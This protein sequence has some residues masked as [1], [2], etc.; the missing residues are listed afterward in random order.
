MRNKAISRDPL[1]Q[2]KYKEALKNESIRLYGAAICWASKKPYKGLIASH[3]KPYKICV[4]EGDVEAEYAIDNGILISKTI[5]DYFDKLLLTFDE[6][7]NMIFSDAVPDTIKDEFSSYSLDSKVYTEQRKKYMRIHRRCKAG[8]H[9][10]HIA[11]R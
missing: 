7:G 9:R 8:K 11:V 3:I 10:H 1:L 6:Q 4:L 2:N 5:D